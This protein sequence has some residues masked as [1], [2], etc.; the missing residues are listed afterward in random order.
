[1][2]SFFYDGVGKKL[3]D[4]DFNLLT[5]TIKVRAMSDTD[6]AADSTDATMTDVTASYNSSTDPIIATPT[7]TGGVFN[8]PDITT[9]WSSLSPDPGKT[10]DYLVI[11][12][13]VTNDA[14][15]TPIACID[16]TT[17]FTPN[18]GN[19]NLTWSGSGIFKI[20]A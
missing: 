12:Q 18:G 13:F 20:L 6:Q 16:L 10:I 7:T 4:G 9:A 11:Y 15:S 2:A 14:G 17:P 8:A 5:D 19:I 3:L 1:M